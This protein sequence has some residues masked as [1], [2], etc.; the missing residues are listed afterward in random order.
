MFA[1]SSQ[2]LNWMFA[3]EGEIKRLKQEV[4][5]VFISNQKNGQTILVSDSVQ[6]FHYE[7]DLFYVNFWSFFIAYQF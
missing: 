3:D 4:N 5:D 6:M 1:T 2:R 7:I